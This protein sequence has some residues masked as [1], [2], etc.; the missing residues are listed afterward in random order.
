MAAD[1]PGAVARLDEDFAEW[2]AGRTPAQVEACRAYQLGEHRL[3]NGVLRGRIDRSQLTRRENVRLVDLRAE[4]D[5]AID[6]GWVTR[7]VIVHRGIRRA[8][9]VL[10]TDRLED[11]TGQERVL[12]GYVS[13][14][15]AASAAERFAAG[16]EAA[17][18][19]LEI[20]A[21]MSAAWLPLVGVEEYRDQA[22]L[23]LPHLT[24]VRLGSVERGPTGRPLIHC[25]VVG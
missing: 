1:G 19:R 20:P 18:L 10:G 15:A 21:G 6:A 24:R 8:E 2:A 12:R 13:T 11:I 23:L 16:I 4:L 14:S 17:V 3:L 7:S 5:D 25:E 9:A 22:E